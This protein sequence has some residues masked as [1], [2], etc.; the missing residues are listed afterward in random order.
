MK[1]WSKLADVYEADLDVLEAARR[2][3]RQ[4]TLELLAVAKEAAVQAGTPLGLDLDEPTEQDDVAF[5]GARS[6]Y[7]TVPL[8][9]GVVLD[10]SAWMA[11]GFGGPAGQFRLALGIHSVPRDETMPGDERQ[12]AHRLALALPDALPGERYELSRF[13][14][15]LG[16]DEAWSRVAS[17]TVGERASTLASTA[18]AMRRLVA[19]GI[20]AAEA[21]LEAEAAPILLAEDALRRFRPELEQ[22]ARVRGLTIK[23]KNEAL[24]RWGGGRYLQVEEIWVQTR[25]AGP[26]RPHRPHHL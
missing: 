15:T 22:L 5:D 24:G 26:R 20:P 6:L 4:R 9:C 7:G 8:A 18:T 17:I 2:A 11:S 12:W 19:E 25:R 23:P 14:D 1:Q 10:V 3:Y 16:D 21:W 13:P